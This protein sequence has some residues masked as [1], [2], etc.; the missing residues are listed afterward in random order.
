MKIRLRK[1]LGELA[2]L[3]IED[4]GAMTEVLEVEEVKRQINKIQQN[5]HN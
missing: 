1:C 3:K 5:I 2:R 4:E